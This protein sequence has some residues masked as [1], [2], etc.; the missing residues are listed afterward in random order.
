MYAYFAAFPPLKSRSC[1]HWK[2]HLPNFKFHFD[3]V[4]VTL[5]VQQALRIEQS[6]WTT[7][8][9]GLVAL[10]PGTAGIYFAQIVTG[11]FDFPCPIL[12]LITSPR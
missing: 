6:Q 10:V 11:T 7:L 2:F 5:C 1:S 8:C 4:L 9:A 3:L 12:N